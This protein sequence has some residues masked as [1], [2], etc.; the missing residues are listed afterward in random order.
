MKQTAVIWLAQQLYEKMNMT[1]DGR[2][3]DEILAEAKAMERQQIEEA[4]SESRLTHP[5]I[6]FKHQTF[7]KYYE[8][9]YGSEKG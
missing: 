7:A 8:T 3:F 5:M 9:T 6:G 1:G 4:F 2:V